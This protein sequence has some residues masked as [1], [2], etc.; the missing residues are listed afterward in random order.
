MNVF[1]VKVASVIDVMSLLS[2]N[3]KY[4]PI[5]SISSSIKVLMRRQ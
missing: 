2:F 1:S 3:T 5:F 4:I